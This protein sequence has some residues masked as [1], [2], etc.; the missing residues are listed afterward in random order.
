MDR[1][2]TRICNK[3]QECIPIGSVPSA[4]VAAGGGVCQGA[5]SAQGVSAGDEGVSARGVSAQRGVYPGGVSQYALGRHP[6][7]NRM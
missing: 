2:L 1:Q 4:A 5:V 3:K 6:P 7:V